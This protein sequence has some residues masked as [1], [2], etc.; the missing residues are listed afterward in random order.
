MKNYSRGTCAINKLKRD[1]GCFRGSTRLSFPPTKVQCLLWVMVICRQVF[2]FADSIRS[3]TVGEDFTFADNTYSS[4]AHFDTSPSEAF[5]VSGLIGSLLLGLLRAHWII[6]KRGRLCLQNLFVQF[7]IITPLGRGVTN[8]VDKRFPI[9]SFWTVQVLA[10]A[11][12][13]CRWLSQ[14]WRV[15]EPATRPGEPLWSQFVNSLARS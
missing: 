15:T 9:F 6:D 1:G 12:F 13:G 4:R 14:L 5:R 2:T 8:L 10:L 3:F 11:D 7:T